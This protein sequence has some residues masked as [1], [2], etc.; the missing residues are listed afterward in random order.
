MGILANILEA[1][2]EKSSMSVASMD[3]TM[4]S[5]KV[6]DSPEKLPKLSWA[7]TLIWTIACPSV[8]V[9]SASD[10]GRVTVG[11]VVSSHSDQAPSLSLNA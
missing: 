11:A 5:A 3:M 6:V 2:I 7:R 4:V 9:I 8:A 10:K 1:S